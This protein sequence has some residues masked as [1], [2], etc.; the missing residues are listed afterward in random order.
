MPFIT[1]DETQSQENLQ[2]FFQDYG[3]ADGQPVILIHGWP[4][5]HRAWEPQMQTLADAGYRVIAY[6]RRGF[7]VSTLPYHNFDYST[8]AKDLR[9]L[10]VEL[11]L[12]KAI[13]VGFSMGGGEVVRYFTAYGSDRIAKAAL[14]SSIVPLVAQKEDNPDG[15][16]QED[17]DDILQAVKT[18]RLAFLRGFIKNYFN[19]EATKTPEAEL[20]YAWN[21]GAFASPRATV[22]CAKTWA[23]ADFRSECANVDVPTLIVH[24]DADGIVPI[25]TAGNQAAKLIPDSQYHIVKNG[26]HGLNLTHR[27]ELNT[28]LVEFFMD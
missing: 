17:L 6:D 14:V 25:A 19:A 28:A 9:T 10:L 8:L 4:L 5:S 12:Q 20:E 16:P 7:G 3:Q 21:L 22:E 15:V 11:D 1:I 24:G 27:E 26:P 13:L 2:L 18:N 23:S